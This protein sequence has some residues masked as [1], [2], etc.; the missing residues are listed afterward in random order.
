MAQTPEQLEQ[1]IWNY[2]TFKFAH[3]KAN[4]TFLAI[5][6]ASGF[7]YAFFTLYI[8]DRKDLIGAETL[9]AKLLVGLFGIA[10]GLIWWMH[11]RFRYAANNTEELLLNPNY[12]EKEEYTNETLDYIVLSTVKPAGFPENITRY[13]RLLN[14]LHAV[15]KMSVAKLRQARLFLLIAQTFFTLAILYLI[16]AGNKE[17]L[18]GLSLENFYL[19][20]AGLILVSS[21]TLWGVSKVIRRRYEKTA[22]NLLFDF[23]SL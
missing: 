10:V 2:Q 14:T 9:Q 11:S 15:N 12:V 13:Q 7:A 22:K 16:A 3:L 20:S 21:L 18:F 4:Q 6:V 17:T 8:L 19:Y 5:M 1:K 23:I